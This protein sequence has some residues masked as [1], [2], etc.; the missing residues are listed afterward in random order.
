VAHL[1]HAV[2]RAASTRP[3]FQLLQT[4][5]RPSSSSA[6]DTLRSRLSRRLAAYYERQAHPAAAPDCH[7]QAG[8]ELRWLEE[9][10]RERGPEW[11]TVLE[12]MVGDMVDSDK[13]LAYVLGASLAL[14]VPSTSAP[15]C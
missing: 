13:P 14:A 9:A 15:S 2:H 10:A 12:R 4:R 5:S 3:S 1:W 7:E 8:Q 6:A 11:D